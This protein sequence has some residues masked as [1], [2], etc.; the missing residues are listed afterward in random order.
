MSDIL[1]PFIN[2]LLVLDNDG[3]RIIA[4]YYLNKNKNEQ[5]KFESGLHKKTKGMTFRS[6]GKNRRGERKRDRK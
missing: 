6:D 5:L 4:K 2:C 3:D 1:V